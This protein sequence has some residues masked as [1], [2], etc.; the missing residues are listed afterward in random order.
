MRFGGKIL[1]ATILMLVGYILS[2]AGDIIDGDFIK[3]FRG[4]VFAGFLV[5]AWLLVWIDTMV[6]KFE[7]RWQ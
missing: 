5:S 3:N 1:A 4:L 2:R 7:N 6:Q